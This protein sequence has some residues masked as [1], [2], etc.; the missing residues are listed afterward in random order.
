MKDMENNWIPVVGEG[1][2][3]L[4][5]GKQFVIRGLLTIGAWANYS[6]SPTDKPT[7]VVGVI[8]EDKNGDEIRFKIS[9]I[10]KEKFLEY[11]TRPTGFGRT[12][13]PAFV[14]TALIFLIITIAAIVG[15]NS[16]GIYVLPMIL[17]SVIGG[18]YS[19]WNNYKKINR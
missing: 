6:P 11:I 8:V 5:T 19:T 18:F 14:F 12:S 4:A 2:V 13:W 17:I 16:G 10:R 9:E 3:E 7:D 15:F 1:C